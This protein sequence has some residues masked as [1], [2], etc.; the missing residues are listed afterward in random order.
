MW[1]FGA[2]TPTGPNLY[3]NARYYDSGFGRFTTQDSFLGRINEPPSLHRFA[4]AH[5]NPLR[6]V[7]PTGHE[8]KAVGV[9]TTR[10]TWD[11]FGHPHIGAV[12]A[13]E[14]ETVEVT[15]YPDRASAVAAELDVN[16]AQPMN[17]LATR[18]MGGVRVVGGGVQVAVGAAGLAVPDPTMVTK[19]AGGVA[20]A[21][22][23]DDIQAG[24]RQLATG[25]VVE[26]VTGTAIRKG[27]EKAG[28]SPETAALISAGGEF[29]IA[30]GSTGLAARGIP[31]PQR[32]TLGRI[33]PEAQAAPK[34]GVEI[35]LKRPAGVTDAQWQKKLDALNAGAAEGRAQVVHRPVRTGTAQRQARAEGRISAGDDA[36]HALDL[37]FG[38]KDT[39]AEIIS[40]NSTVNRSVGAQGR[41][42]LR[43][44][45]GTPINRFRE[46]Q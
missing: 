11:E 35:T 17:R 7:D 33:T 39:P 41:Q 16:L 22:G 31:S 25:V 27:A 21:H 18:G 5:Q 2:A 37:Q 42:R 40:T 8:V 45:D 10:I 4:Y 9:D 15:A 1:R 43:H 28:A 20:I 19:V 26:T 46:E 36:D 3:A 30:A 14:T 12:V 38:G 6:Y 34:S 44:P 24:L 32:T 13:V 23:V 29:V